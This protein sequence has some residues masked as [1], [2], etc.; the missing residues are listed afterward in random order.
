M[1]NHEIMK[2][3]N[4]IEELFPVDT[5]LVD[6]IHVWPLIRLS[7]ASNLYRQGTEQPNTN[8]II[9]RIA[10]KIKGFFVSLNALLADRE[11]NAPY[12]RKTNAVILS[13]TIC[14]TRLDNGW[15]DRICDPFVEELNSLGWSS[16][17]YEATG[18]YEYRLPRVYES[19][20]I[21]L[22][23]DFV[24]TISSI[25]ALFNRNMKYY[26]ERWAEFIEF[27]NRKK[28]IQYIPSEKE[29]TSRVFKLKHLSQLFEYLLKHNQP[30]LAFVECYYGDQGMAF[31]LA[32]NRCGIPSIDI[33]HG[34]QGEYH[35]A[36]GQW[37]RVPDKGY[38]LLPT[39]FWCWTS[40]EA[41]AINKWS[42]TIQ[43]KVHTALVGSNLWLNK[44][45]EGNIPSLN[46][47]DTIIRGLIEDKTAII[48]T[49]QPGFEPDPWFYEAVTKSHKDWKWFIRLHPVMS[50]EER[51]RIE[52]LFNMQCTNACIEIDYASELPLL[53]WLRH[54][55]IHV[56]QYSSSVI[57]AEAF[58][59]PSIITHVNGIDIYNDQIKNN[60]AYTA[61]NTLDLISR[62]N[63]LSNEKNGSKYPNCSKSKQNILFEQLIN[64][65]LEEH[66]GVNPINSIEMC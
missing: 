8:T 24:N 45:I 32:C 46:I 57:E 43:A 9:N 59:V 41:N 58:G 60:I 62:I 47:Y 10:R 44:W 22:K 21:Q 29:L 14:R 6:D 2:L 7:L 27:C 37:N 23:I 53:A 66:S 40:A 15:Y 39:Y 16:Q 49:L 3:I 4:E 13:N 30:R 35:E 5:W 61:F 42:Q 55:H 38:E 17:F 65:I 12:K 56:T 20:L 18:S 11:H 50:F 48:F 33:Q 1:N 19:T 31:D 25:S 26:L 34:V 28:V 54:I 52:N 64:E 36:Y 51:K 63:I